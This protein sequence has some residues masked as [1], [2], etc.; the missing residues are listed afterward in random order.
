MSDGIVASLISILENG[1][2]QQAAAAFIIILA[3]TRF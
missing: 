3:A 1:A 2:R